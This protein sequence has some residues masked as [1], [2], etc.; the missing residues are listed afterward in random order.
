M[1]ET[2]A[3]ATRL[4]TSTDADAIA[5]LARKAL[6]EGEEERALRTIG[7]AVARSPDASLWQWKA[8]LERSLD[9]HEEALASFEAAARLAP[10]DISIAHGHAR[11]A[12][13]AGLDARPLYEHALELAPHNGQ[14]LVGMA[15]A[16]D[17]LD[18]LLSAP[19]SRPR[20]GAAGG[21]GRARLCL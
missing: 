19:E 16:R 5:E 1:S 3:L 10:A 15:A 7:R 17:A 11:T 21:G 4:A 20:H 12:M 18:A 13:E 9:E 8:L 6:E 14:I 2:A